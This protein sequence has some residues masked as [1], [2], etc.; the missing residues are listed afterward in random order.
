MGWN[1][2]PLPAWLLLDRWSLPS[3]QGWDCL[4]WPQLCARPKY[5]HLHRSLFLLQRT[6]LRLSAQLLASPEWSL[7]VLPRWNL[8]GGQLLQDRIGQPPCLHPA[9]M[10]DCMELILILYLHQTIND[11]RIVGLAEVETEMT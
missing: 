6:I 3:L 1:V 2:L 11:I 4:R 7:R 9:L 5:P 8:L 10:T